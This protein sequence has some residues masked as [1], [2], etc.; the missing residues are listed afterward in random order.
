[1]VKKITLSLIPLPSMRDL[2][3]YEGGRW[4]RRIGAVYFHLMEDGGFVMHVVTD[5]TNGDW[6]IN[7]Y[8]QKRIY[9]STERIS[10]EKS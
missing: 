9:V 5:R 7:Q 1:M 4:Q 8:K 2:Q 10:A 6:L 3:V